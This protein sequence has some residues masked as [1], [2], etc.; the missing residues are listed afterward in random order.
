MLSTSSHLSCLY[1]TKTTP[2][3]RPFLCRF[4]FQNLDTSKTSTRV[5]KKEA[6]KETLLYLLGRH[7]SILA[8]LPAAVK[9]LKKGLPAPG[10]GAGSG[11]SQVSPGVLVHCGPQSCGTLCKQL[12]EGFDRAG[13]GP[14]GRHVGGG[15]PPLPTGTLMIAL[16]HWAPRVAQ[17]S[18]RTNKEHRPDCGARKFERRISDQEAEHRTVVRQKFER[19]PDLFHALH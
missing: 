11:S 14:I 12:L 6:K 3:W 18:G 10:T 13:N 9:F 5:G 4:S 16:R 1:R 15:R 2:E 19:H 7:I 8:G 17:S